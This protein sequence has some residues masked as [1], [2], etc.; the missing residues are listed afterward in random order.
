MCTWSCRLSLLDSIK[1]NQEGLSLEILAVKILDNDDE[2]SG[3]FNMDS[4]KP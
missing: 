1:I 4:S 2:S 3:F